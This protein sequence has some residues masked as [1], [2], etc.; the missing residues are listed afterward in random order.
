MKKIIAIV[1]AAGFFVLPLARAFE[2]FNVGTVSPTLSNPNGTAVNGDGYV[3]VLVHNGSSGG[4]VEKIDPSTGAMSQFAN[5]SAYKNP[6]FLTPDGK[7]GF[8]SADIVSLSI[9]E[10]SSSG[11]VTKLAGQKT[12]SPEII[13]GNLGSA[14][15]ANIQGLAGDDKGDVFISDTNCIREL[16][17]SNATVITIAGSPQTNGSL[18]YVDGVGTAARFSRPSYLAV[19]DFGDV[20]VTDYGN[21]VVRK[22]A[23][24]GTVS[25]LA[26]RAGTSG[27]INGQGTAAEFSRL[28]GIAVDSVGNVF[29]SDDN[30]NGVIRKITSTGVVTSPQFYVDGSFQ[31]FVA[32]IDLA[33]DAAGT[34]YVTDNPSG[35]SSSWVVKTVQQA[36]IGPSAGGRL[37]NLSTRGLVDANPLI[38]GFVI[39]GSDK[40]SLQVLGRGVGP[41]LAQFSVPNVLAAATLTLFDSNSNPVEAN[42]GWDSSSDHG[43]AIANADGETGAFA[44]P[45]GSLDA[46]LLMSGLAPGIRTIQVSG[47]GGKTGVALVELYAVPNSGTARL[48]NLST[49]GDVGTGQEIL[50]AGLVI[51][52]SVPEKVLIRGVGPTLSKFGV[53]GVLPDPVLVLF[54]K[55]GNKIGMNAGWQG[56]SVLAGIFTETGAFALSPTSKD[57]AMVVTLPPG[58]YTCQLSGASGDTGNAMIEVYELP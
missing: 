6:A 30:A 15:F 43:A 23:P 21:Y 20:F 5:L 38:A 46:A 32:P 47:Q 41:T 34:M 42:S 37:I 11:S 25:T 51:G 7:G 16:S 28:Y 18:G 13:D 24:D 33:I 54:D 50:D 3:Y 4:T 29:V 31:N 19:D 57:D 36:N 55:D 49:R 2:S 44:L 1:S 56:D 45:A 14:V 35:G 22:I 27:W 26:G 40:D 48:I 39:G 52:G 12:P 8:F 58:Q 17:L 53:N 10:I 9:L